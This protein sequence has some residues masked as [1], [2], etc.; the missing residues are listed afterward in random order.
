MSLE[1]RLVD[2]LTVASSTDQHGNF[3]E[4]WQDSQSTI[5]IHTGLLKA[6]ER[7]DEFSDP[8]AEQDSQFSGKIT[9]RLP[10]P[11]LATP[12][13]ADDFSSPGIAP[14]EQITPSCPSSFDALHL[15][16]GTRQSALMIGSSVASQCAPCT[17]SRLPSGCFQRNTLHLRAWKGTLRLPLFVHSSPTTMDSQAQRG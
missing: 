5:L 2:K 1:S 17:Q 7:I 13:H 12:Y 4:E 8:T 3:C 11:V 9:D 6:I 16:L 15:D 10:T 14:T